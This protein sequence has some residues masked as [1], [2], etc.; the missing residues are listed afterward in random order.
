M[1]TA[2]AGETSP[3]RHE[4]RDCQRERQRESPPRG[5]WNEDQ[6]RTERPSPQRTSARVRVEVC[7]VCVSVCGMCICRPISLLGRERHRELLYERERLR[8][9]RCA[10]AEK[11]RWQGQYVRARRRCMGV[12]LG[13][14]ARAPR[15][16]APG[17]AGQSRVLWDPLILA[18]KHGLFT[19]QRPNFQRGRCPRHNANHNP[20]NVNLTCVRYPLSVY[21]VCPSRELTENSQSWGGG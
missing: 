7:G 9:E 3:V 19:G 2:R 4:T 15:G 17:V 14:V 21:M 6:T 16:R 13:C 20:W 1:F 8:V 18:S 5:P 11:C 10:R 12:R